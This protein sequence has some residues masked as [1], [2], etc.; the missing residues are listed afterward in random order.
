MAYYAYSTLESSV[1]EGP[2]VIR[3]GV[4]PANVDRAIDAIDHEV[5]TLAVDGPTTPEFEDSRHA[6]I[7]SIPRIL[8]TNDGIAEFLQTVEQF[9]LGLDHDRRFREALEAVT[10]DDVAAAA[11]D[12]LQT[13]RAAIAV[14]GPDPRAAEASV[15]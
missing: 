6:L 4:D 15:A 8:E 3:V 5:R 2:L 14:A 11:H 9:D 10:I 13:D 1:G 7:G 12:V